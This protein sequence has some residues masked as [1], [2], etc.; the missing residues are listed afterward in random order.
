MA[1]SALEA[2]QDE[3]AKLLWPWPDDYVEEGTP[4]AVLFYGRQFAMAALKVVTGAAASLADEDDG[5]PG[6]LAEVLNGVSMA[7][8][9]FTHALVALEVLPPEAEEAMAGEAS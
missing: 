6:P 2:V 1:D 8:V 9:G 4:P 5:E 7:V 3:L